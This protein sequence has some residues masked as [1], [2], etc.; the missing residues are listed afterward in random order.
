[1]AGSTKLFQRA[2]SPL[3][4]GRS[5]NER[6]FWFEWALACLASAVGLYTFLGVTTLL[7]PT[8]PYLASA[9]AL[10]LWLALPAA[11]LGAMLPAAALGSWL[12]RLMGWRGAWVFGALVGAV[13]GI[14]VMVYAWR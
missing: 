5:R 12:G 4:Q 1:M 2:G 13:V 10:M 11:G 7:D 6:S 8:R 9:E 14:V 3:I